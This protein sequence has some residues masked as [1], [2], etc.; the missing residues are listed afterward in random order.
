MKFWK[1]FCTITRHRHLVMLHCF[2][3]GIPRQGLLHDLSKYSPAEFYAGIR[4][5]QGTRSPNEGEREAVGYS[6]AWMHHKGRN[7]HHFEYWTDYIPKEHKMM[8]VRMP[9]RFVAE[10]FCDR[11]AASKVYMGK[12]Y[13]QRAPLDY[14]LSVKGK[15]V[16]HPETSDLVEHFLTVLAE[17]GEDAAFAEVRRV[18]ADKSI[19]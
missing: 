11:M 4:Y 3:A 10:M 8:P 19:P 14:F 5:Y 18:L 13:T 2:R 1:H 12:K 17:S 15:R 9:K 7:R 6:A 16:I